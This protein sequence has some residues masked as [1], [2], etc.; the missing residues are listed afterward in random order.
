VGEYMKLYGYAPFAYCPHAY[1]AVM[2]LKQ[3]IEKAKST[4]TEKVIAVLEGGTFDTPWGKTTIRKGDHQ[5]MGKIFIGEAKPSPQYKF[6]VLSDI[7]VIP[8]ETVSLPV[9]ET[10]CKME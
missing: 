1:G 7:K 2:I 9:E 8:C 6:W 5:A 3:A 4:D 10:G